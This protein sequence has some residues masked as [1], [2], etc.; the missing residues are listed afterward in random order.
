MYFQLF[1]WSGMDEE[2][3]HFFKQHLI[4]FLVYRH[5]IPSVVNITLLSLDADV[6]S[7]SCNDTPPYSF[8]WYPTMC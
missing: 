6:D 4:F 2:S 8:T 5:S 1:F 3:F 7:Q